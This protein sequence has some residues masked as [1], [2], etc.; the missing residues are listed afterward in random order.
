MQQGAACVGK[1][2][3]LARGG[4]VPAAPERT[5]SV[6]CS[7]DAAL[8]APTDRR[9]GKV[10]N[11]VVRVHAC[12]GRLIA[13]DRAPTLAQAVGDVRERDGAV[14][15][16]QPASALGPSAKQMSALLLGDRPGDRSP[17][18]SRESEPKRRRQRRVCARAWATDGRALTNG[19]PLLGGGRAVRALVAVGRPETGPH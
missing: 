7:T 1:T 10:S 2:R 18:L 4:S 12:G 15:L 11:H 9:R 5:V 19:S 13:L 16:G 6:V 14:A 3:V 8:C 17:L